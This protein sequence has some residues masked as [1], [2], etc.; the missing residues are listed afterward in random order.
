MFRYRAYQKY[1][2]FKKGIETV[3][4]FLNRLLQLSKIN[5]ADLI[6]GNNVYAHVPDINDF[7]CD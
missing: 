6:I 7:T 3:E 1:C 5:K 4:E 2:S